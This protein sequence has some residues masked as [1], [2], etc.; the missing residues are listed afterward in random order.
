VRN[1]NVSTDEELWALGAAHDGRAFGELFERHADAIYNHCFRRTGSWSLAEDLT[2]ITFMET[3]RRRQQV[4][5]HGESILPW[6]L[7]V[8]NNA[9]RNGV[10]SQRRYRRLLAKLP[11]ATVIPDQ[12][13]EAIGRV[14]DERMMSRILPAFAQL[15]DRDQDVLSLCDWAG[16]SYEEAA[17]SLNIPVGTV[18]SRLSRA[19]TRIRT[20]LDGVSITTPENEHEIAPVG[21]P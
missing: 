16:L 7:A 12:S 6:L 17:A 15:D 8:A 4:R 5:L 19:R 11:S 2:S 18:R 14:D 20:F 3:W 10:R 21:G 9:I 13:D 1:Y